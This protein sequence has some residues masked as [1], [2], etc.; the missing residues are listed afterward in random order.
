MLYVAL[1]KEVVKDQNFGRK[2][3][4][5][6]ISNH[7]NSIPD[8]DGTNPSFW[9]DRKI[10]REKAFG[11][12]EPM[13]NFQGFQSAALRLTKIPYAVKI[14][15]TEGYSIWNFCGEHFEENEK[16][17][18]VIAEDIAVLHKTYWDLPENKRL[19]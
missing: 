10:D 13:F 8:K 6:L 3:T 12:F 18:P 9:P 16:M 5:R 7:S 2:F 11:T 1:R 17:P 15:E 19:P 14:G 4:M